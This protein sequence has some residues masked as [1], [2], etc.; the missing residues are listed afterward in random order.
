MER[1]RTV[2]GGVWILG[3]VFLVV[4]LLTIAACQ[5]LRDL[6]R[7][8]WGGDVAASSDANG[9]PVP[10][11]DPWTSPG[12]TIVEWVAGLL[13]IAGYGGLARWIHVTKKASNSGLADIRSRLDALERERS[14]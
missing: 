9:V 5:P 7:W 13:A 14:S 6:D 8:A 12:G 10:A 1:L 3:G 4:L 2:G 11:A